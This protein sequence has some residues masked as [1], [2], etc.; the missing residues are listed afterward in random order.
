MKRILSMIVLGSVFS[1]VACGGSSAD[2]GDEGAQEGS[3]AATAATDT[4]ATSSD[5]DAGSAPAAKDSGATSSDKDTGTAPAADTGSGGG[6]ADTGAPTGSSDLAGKVNCGDKGLVCTTASAACC[7]AYNPI[8]GSTFSCTGSCSGFG[9]ISVPCDGPEDCSG[10][11]V[12]CF[13]FDGSFS[14]S[15]KCESK[16]TCTGGT[17]NMAISCHTNADCPSA[18]TCLE[19]SDPG[20]A[21]KVRQCVNGGKCP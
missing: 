6:A 7:I 12:C 13:R 9:K 3:D 2:L 21:V 16:T 4:G 18:M 15:A 8:S 20:G 10:G 14:A 17:R 1:L 5:K 11:N 19:C